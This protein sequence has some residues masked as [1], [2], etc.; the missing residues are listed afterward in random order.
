VVGQP[1]S[2]LLKFKYLGVNDTTGIFQFL[3]AK[4]APTYSPASISNNQLNDMHDIGNLDPKFYGGLSNSFGYKN[5][6]LDIFFEFK[7]QTG[8]NYLAQVYGGYVPGTEVNLPVTFLSRWQKPGDKSEFEKL[9][10]DAIT[11]AGIAARR[12]FTQ[13]SGVYS[14]ASYIRLKTVS[15]SYTLQ[16][17]H[18]GK[19]KA[20]AVRFYI[21][22]ENVF[23]MTDYKGNDPETQSFYGVPPLRTVVAGCQFNF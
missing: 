1:L 14:D 4:G 5:F 3:D 12:Y 7:K 11:P 19:I 8:I 13:S 17:K 20:E 21:N 22:A 9:T 2:V 18:L 15:L 23:T 10:T 6:H 16:G